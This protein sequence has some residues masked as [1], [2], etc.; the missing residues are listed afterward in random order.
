MKVI[1][2]LGLRT[3]IALCVG[4]IVL[5]TGLAGA[6]FTHEVMTTKLRGELEERGRDIALSLEDRSVDHILRGNFFELHQMIQETRANSND[7][8]YIFV[9]DPKGNIIDHT[10][11][12]GFPTDLLSLL[13][14]ESGLGHRMQ[15][16]QTEE[17][18]IRDIA[19][20]VFDGKAGVLHIGMTETSL[21]SAV[22]EVVR[23]LL[24]ATGIALLVGVALAWFF[25]HLVTRPV[26]QLVGVADAVRDGNLA[27]RA[28]ITTRDEIGR[29]GRAF[30]TMTEQLAIRIEELEDRNLQLS[31][32]NTIATLVSGTEPTSGILSE[33]LGKLLNLVQAD[34]GGILFRNH[35]RESGYW[36]HVGFSQAYVE[37][38][39]SLMRNS[40]KEEIELILNRAEYPVSEFKPVERRLLSCVERE[41]LQSFASAPFWVKGEIHGTL[42][43][44]RRAKLPF[45]PRELE[46]LSSVAAQTGI[47]LTNRQLLR[48]A[49]QAEA[50]RHLNQMKSE[51]AV[52]ASHELRTPATAIKGYIETLL[53]PDMALDRNVQKQLLEDMNEVSDRLN[54]LIQ[55]VLNVARID[56]GG[57]G[58]R[59]ERLALRPLLQR[60]TR[61]LGRQSPRPRLVVELDNSLGDIL[62]DA[63]QLED[64]LENLISNAYKYSPEGGTVT[65]SARKSSSPEDYDQ[66]RIGKTSDVGTRPAQ[67]VTI[68]VADEGIGIVAQEVPKLFQRFYQVRDKRSNRSGGIGMGLFICKSYVEAM[69]GKIWV[70]SEQGKGSIF[71]FT[72]PVAGS[73][74]QRVSGRESVRNMVNQRR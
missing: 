46:L 40:D 66:L 38:V 37:G 61:R 35:E 30:D 67:F 70:K 12:S 59:K 50:L 36:A 69:G 14:P 26:L 55:G 23:I 27:R 68:S 49:S 19:V 34:A 43:V 2:H 32:L 16:L 60:I 29:L 7:V 57:P 73:S 10:F 54:R 31:A 9:L 33:I 44:T 51:F 5:L 56:S 62:G 39:A 18:F 28:S 52:R 72:I 21:N 22:S 15:L 3:K 71:S 48:E 42:H 25:A 53:R 58:V 20:P 64:I 63:D 8:R 24:I 13:G 65:L 47:M 41:G 6:V 1:K 74:R 11:E 4:V 17:E 45:M